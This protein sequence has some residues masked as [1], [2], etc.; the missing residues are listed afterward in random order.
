MAVNPLLGALVGGG[1]NYLGASR[2]ADE[3]DEANKRNERYRQEGRDFAR[4]H[5]VT[6]AFGDTENISGVQLS[7]GSQQL[8]NTLQGNAQQQATG[9]S[10]AFRNFVS[11]TDPLTN[12]TVPE[13]NT[14]AGDIVER[15]IGRKQDLAS[16]LAN[17]AIEST[18][19]RTGSGSSNFNANAIEAAAN[20]TNQFNLGK[21]KDQYNLG[22]QMYDDFI[23]RSLLTGQQANQGASQFAAQNIP[24]GPSYGQSVAAFNSS[25]IPIAQPNPGEGLGF[26]TGAQ[27][28]RDLL[29]RQAAE[30][31]QKDQQNFIL[32]LAKRLQGNQVSAPTTSAATPAALEALFLEGI[33]A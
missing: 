8:M 13:F 15:D 1:L 26:A 2:Q 9:A 18:I 4:T 10:N 23:K 19:R 5:S 17:N 25:P 27:T 32:E 28:L 3:Q 12:K 7:P 31:S 21:E 29:S 16:T 22:T 11:G 30:R 20:A 24:T 14:Y 33:G 6:N